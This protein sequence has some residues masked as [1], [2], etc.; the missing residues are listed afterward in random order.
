MSSRPTPLMLRELPPVIPVFP[1]SGAVLL[2]RGRLPL[3]IFEPRYLAMVRDALAAE[4]LIG[5]VQPRS[6]AP[7]AVPE[8]YPVGCLGKISAFSETDDGRF[9]ITL[10]GV[11]RFR[12]AEELGLATPYRQV[13]PRF[14]DFAQDLD[15]EA[16]DQG[17][18][19]S[20]LIP[21]L[22][23]YLDLH[24]MS[25]DWHAVEQAGAETL[26]NTL[27]MTCPFDPAEKQALVEAPTVAAR[28][29]TMITLIRMAVAANTTPPENSLQ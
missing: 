2:P 26:V 4:R 8:L 11:C 28:A 12:I 1:L 13:V 21:A 19:R 27:A 15:P 18:D 20:A 29:E 14:E 24:G 16:A 9:L 25:A 6:A 17:F 22:K 3:N 10:S 7:T 23:A 5:M